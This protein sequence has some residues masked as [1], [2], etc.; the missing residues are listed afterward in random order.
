MI[1]GAKSIVL[2]TSGQ[3]SINPR[4]VK[5]ADAL[6]N[7]G[8]Q[9]TVLYQFWSHW[10]EHF[11]TGLLDKKPWRSI[12]IG[13]SPR[14][15]RMTYLF[16]RVLHKAFRTVCRLSGF[17]RGRA[18]A[19]LGRCTELLYAAAVGIPADL[20]IAHN[21][22]ALAPAVRAAKNRGV[23][24]GFDAEDFHRNEVADAPT[25]FD[26]RIKT[27]I[28]QKY[29]WQLDHFTTS[30]PLIASK[31][32]ALFPKLHIT[33]IRNVFPR[34]DCPAY[35]EAG[36]GEP[37]R[38]FWF[39][40]TLNE[41]RG[42]EQIIEALKLIDNPPEL[43]LLG[44]CTETYRQ[45]IMAYAAS[46][47]VD[48][49]LICLHAPVSPMDL[50]AVAAKFDIGIASETGIPANREICL[51]NKLFTYIQSGLLMLASD[52][53][54]QSLFLQ[55]YPQTGAIYRRADSRSLAY[56]ISQY[57]K[58]PSALQG[59]RKI[60]YQLGQTSMNWET[61]QVSFLAEISKTLEPS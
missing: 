57:L 8:Y 41:N 48:G 23:K 46:I 35:R 1:Q 36:V 14:R 51:T 2:I 3:P 32:A 49:R 9:V 34:K 50:M 40:Q 43:H 20:Y 55:E 44:S 15:N 52:T 7:A 17:T 37:V 38:L 39:S 53:S 16:T 28:E 22:A 54:A 19:S 59:I 27:F 58:E 31:Y 24:C 5:E 30:S 60:N 11:D 26:V 47:G 10:A 56:Q 21:L 18:E 61:E 33:V 12:L 4:L 42:I 13:G 29:F 45:Q 25:D 6:H